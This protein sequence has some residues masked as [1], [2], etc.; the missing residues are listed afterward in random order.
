[1]DDQTAARLN[2]HPGVE[3][4]HGTLFVGTKGWVKV[5]R[6]GWKVSDEKLYRLGKNPGPKRLEVSTNQRYNFIDS[7]ISRKQPVDNLH[8]A[9]RS[10]II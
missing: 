4:Y 7:V 2:L 10:D 6:E 3:P 5:K 8:S 1:M 9:S